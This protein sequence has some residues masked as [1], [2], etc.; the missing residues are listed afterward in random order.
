MFLAS[1]STIVAEVV[2]SLTVPFSAPRLP[3]DAPITPRREIAFTSLPLDK[4][5]GVAHAFEVTINDV[6]LAVVAGAMRRFLVSL[7]KLPEKPLVAAVPVSVRGDH[8]VEQA[9]MV[10][11]M[12]TGLATDLEDPADRLVA[13]HHA[14]SEAKLLQ[15]AVGSEALM[16]W[17]EV[18]VPALFSL[19]TSLYAWLRLSALHPPLCNVLVSDVPG[20]PVPLYFAGAR[21]E[22]IFPLGPIFDGVG[23]NI[24]AVSSADTLDIG[25]VACPDQLPDLWNLASGLRPA[26]EELDAARRSRGGAKT[27]SKAKKARQVGLLGIDPL[28]RG[29]ATGDGRRKS[30]TPSPKQEPLR[31]LGNGEVSTVSQ[32][33]AC[34]LTGWRVPSPRST[35]GS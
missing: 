13:I 11:V 12:L 10:S 9:N 3:F 16:E 7:G 4:I 24:T 35:V 29:A 31:W 33:L 30:F 23:L 21:L 17:L 34:A 5:K 8:G 19:A 6:V 22:S 26:L 1:W 27:S 15:S 25:L 20:P 2:P 18:P 28:I 32:L 14:A